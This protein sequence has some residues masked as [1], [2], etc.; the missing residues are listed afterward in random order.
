MSYATLLSSPLHARNVGAVLRATASF[1]GDALWF[2]NNRIELE[3]LTRI[4]RE[5][6]MKA[7]AD[8]PWTQLL[9]RDA[10]RPID[11]IERTHPGYTPVIVE[12]V[13]NATPLNYFE[14]PENALYIF[15]PED[16]HVPIGL[17]T[18]GHHFVSIPSLHCLNLATAATT[19]FY[20]RIAKRVANGQQPLPDL[21]GEQR[22]W[23][24]D[25]ALEAITLV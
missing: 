1:G 7:Y 4:P 22:G 23:Y 11:A 10:V 24:H 20:D 13:P 2:T 19:V 17:R 8:T 25:D 6:R 15:G 16:G 3:K 14:H 12:L 18:M 9:D 5:E 21:N